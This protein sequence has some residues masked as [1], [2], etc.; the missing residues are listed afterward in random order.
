MAWR[1]RLRTILL[2]VNLVILALPLG[3]IW[4]LRIYES[5]L[6]RQTESELIAQ[7]AFVAAS[8]RAIL[9]RIGIDEMVLASF[10]DYGRALSSPWDRAPFRSALA[11]ASCDP[12]FGDRHH[13]S[14]LA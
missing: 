3:G 8:Y 9:M 13:L 6:I 5:A 11:A 2:I 7:G 12:G 10:A 4:V 14:A 1:P